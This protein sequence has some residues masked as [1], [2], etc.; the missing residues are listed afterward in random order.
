MGI[1]AEVWGKKTFFF[2]WLWQVMFF[3]HP[4]QNNF[5]VL[6]GFTMGYETLHFKV[7][8]RHPSEGTS[9]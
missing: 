7:I 4:I 1:K 2:F 9:W 8:C 3:F 5:G 6:G